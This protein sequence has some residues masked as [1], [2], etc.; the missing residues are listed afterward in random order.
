MPENI[1]FLL[2]LLS[3]LV[4][5]QNSIVSTFLYKLMVMHLI[6]YILL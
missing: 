4:I 1:G 5:V 2:I 6:T 3:F